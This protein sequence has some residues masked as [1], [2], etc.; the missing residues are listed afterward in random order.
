M[1]ISAPSLEH[2]VAVIAT[3]MGQLVSTLQATNAL[4]DQIKNNLPNAPHNPDLVA[5][6]NTLT[7][8]EQTLNKIETDISGVPATALKVLFGSPR[9]KV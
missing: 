9:T 6:N 5:I 8:M 1:Q 2:H 3:Y 7:D 4:L